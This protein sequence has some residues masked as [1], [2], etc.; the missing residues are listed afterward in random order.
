MLAQHNDTFI[1]LTVYGIPE[2]AGIPILTN[3]QQFAS[4]RK[5]CPSMLSMFISFY[6]TLMATFCTIFVLQWVSHVKR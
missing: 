1:L 5:T 2:N 3:K 6:F 4:L